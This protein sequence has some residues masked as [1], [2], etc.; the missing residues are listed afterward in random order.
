MPLRINLTHRL[1]SIG[2][3]TIGLPVLPIGCTLRFL[4]RTRRAL[5]SF[6]NVAAPRFG[7]A[8]FARSFFFLHGQQA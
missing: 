7:G 3:L 1:F 5:F 6:I 2:H 8:V 4:D